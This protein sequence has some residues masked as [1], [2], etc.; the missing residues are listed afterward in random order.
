MAKASAKTLKDLAKNSFGIKL[1]TDA[2][3]LDP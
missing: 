3:S 1:T 2:C